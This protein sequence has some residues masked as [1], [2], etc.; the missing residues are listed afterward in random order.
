MTA[1]TS[2]RSPL[3]GRLA[4]LIDRLRSSILWLTVLVVVGLILA[5]WLSGVFSGSG[6]SLGPPPGVVMVGSSWVA[7]EPSLADSAA[8]AGIE[9]RA[10]AIAA[11][12]WAARQA[13]I[14]E[15][16]AAKRA[17]EQ[18]KRDDAL[19]KYEE[20]RAKQLAAYHALLLK[21]QAE[22]AAAEAKAAAARR[23]YQKKLAEYLAKL[24]VTPGAECQD[25][26]VRRV[27]N[28]TPGMLPHH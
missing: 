19:R 4:A 20:E 3:R 14:A 11:S 16:A 15:I 8:F 28:C 22:R 24:K 26:A 5:A 27:Y 10:V 9:H 6:P 7:G 17:A 1:I 13:L 25:P 23:E 18:R 2:T 12:R 21:I